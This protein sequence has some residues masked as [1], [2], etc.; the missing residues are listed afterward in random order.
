[1][2]LG[3]PTNLGGLEILKRYMVNEIKDYHNSQLPE[4]ENGGMV[5][6]SKGLH[7][8]EQYYDYVK[9]KFQTTDLNKLR[10]FHNDDFMVCI[11]Q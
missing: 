6:L 4:L 5:V 8:Y 3:L 11:G 2:V 9:T 7:V 10:E 1:M